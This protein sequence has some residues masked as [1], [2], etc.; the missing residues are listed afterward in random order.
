MVA[1]EGGDAQGREDVTGSGFTF[2]RIHVARA[3]T[4]LRPSIQAH[5]LGS[6]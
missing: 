6:V 1:R 4:P 2:V 3:A 5:H